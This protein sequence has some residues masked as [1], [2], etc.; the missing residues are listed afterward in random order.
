MTRL[1]SRLTSDRGAGECCRCSSPESPLL[2][3][4]SICVLW[5]RTFPGITPGARA[6]SF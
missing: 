4:A 3:Q 2:Q 1:V 5:T 6:K